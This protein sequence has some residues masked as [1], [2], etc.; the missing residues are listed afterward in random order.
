MSFRTMKSSLLSIIPTRKEV[1]GLKKDH[2]RLRLSNVTDSL[3]NRKLVSNRLAGNEHHPLLKG[4]QLI[5]F[6]YLS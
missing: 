3:Y 1:P 5:S 4:Q 6:L 2:K